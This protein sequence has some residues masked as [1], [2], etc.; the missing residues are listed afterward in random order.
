MKNHSKLFLIK[1]IVFSKRA[2]APL[3]LVIKINQRFHQ[4]LLSSTTTGALI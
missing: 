3:C 4:E 1:N 2:K